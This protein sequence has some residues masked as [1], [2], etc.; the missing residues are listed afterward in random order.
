MR[1]SRNK[2]HNQCID[3][4]LLN[5]W[6]RIFNK[7]K[8]GYSC[9]EIREWLLNEYSI[10]V[11]SKH[12]SNKVKEEGLLRNPSERKINAIKRGRMVYRKKPAHEL[13]K[14]GSISAKTRFTVL[15]RDKFKCTLC[16]NSPE[17]GY[18]IEIHHKN[19][20]SSDLNNL[21]TL[22]YLCHKGL[23]YSKRDGH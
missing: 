16:N 19:G 11:S 12:L 22:C 3:A 10:K 15:T 14:S 23:H 17:T 6:K 2:F 7:Y 5:Y 9:D 8:R 20:T 4:G 13:Y 1:D 21:Q 18:T